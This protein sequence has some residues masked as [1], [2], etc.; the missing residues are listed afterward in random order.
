MPIEPPEMGVALGE[1]PGDLIQ[2]VINLAGA[3]DGA[4]PAKQLDR[5]LVIG[6]WN[7]REFGGVTQRWVAEAGD[8]PKRNVGDVWC[9]RES[10]L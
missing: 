1:P 9:I 5:N 10:E 7:L 3:L 2:S 6:S 4:L 8:K